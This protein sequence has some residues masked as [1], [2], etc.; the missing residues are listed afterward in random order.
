L[1]A[2]RHIRFCNHRD[3]DALPSF[4]YERVLDLGPTHAKLDAIADS[5]KV[6]NPNMFIT[7]KMPVQGQYDYGKD[8][9]IALHAKQ[10]RLPAHAPGECQG[11]VERL[12]SLWSRSRGWA[13][14][15]TK[16]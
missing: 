15:K 6:G 2:Y 13:A 10:T 9:T 8:E 11:V 3:F 12:I 1:P 4:K 14:N 16:N 5:A 7:G